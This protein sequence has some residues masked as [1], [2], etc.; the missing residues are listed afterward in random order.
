MLFGLHDLN[1][2]VMLLLTDIYSSSRTKSLI[3]HLEGGGL[4][5]LCGPRRTT[6]R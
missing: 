2:I 6:P 3:A 1:T 4:G 5:P